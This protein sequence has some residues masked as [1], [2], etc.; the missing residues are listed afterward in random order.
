[1]SEFEVSKNKPVCLK[2]RPQTTK[3]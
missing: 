2:S 3:E 1:M